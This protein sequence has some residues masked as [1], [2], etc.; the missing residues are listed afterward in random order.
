MANSRSKNAVLNISVGFGTQILILLLSFIGRKIFVHFLELDYLGINGLYSNIL[1][2]LA[3]AELGLGNV[4]QFFLYKPV[5]END[6]PLVRYLVKYFGKMYW[7]IAG[8]VFLLGVLLMP[9]LKYF[10]NSDLPQN[11]LLIYY[12]L[13]LLNSVVSYFAADKIALLAA[14]QDNRLQ[15]YILLLTNTLAQV[16][17]IIVLVVWHNY[18]FYVSVTLLMSILNV[19]LIN[20]ICR[21]KYSFL[22][23][24]SKE[25]P[26]GFDKHCIIDN[27]KSTFMY[28]IGATIVNN[29]DNI[30]ISAMI[31]TAAVGL[32]SNYQMVV[33]AIQGF[34]AIVSTSLISGIGNLSATGNKKR[35]NSVFNVILLLYHLIAAYG[36]IAF[37]F[38]FQDLIDRKSVV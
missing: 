5:V 7:C 32:Y 27:V 22:Y 1:S 9:F 19:A 37:Y 26:E 14:Y 34:I 36:A 33:L 16:G 8:T 10:I 23:E 38:L 18:F 20:L 13:F 2:V 6:K 12:V 4:T 28:K 21:K 15:K 25:K 3:L 29:T 11:E 24:K 35:M 17:Y 31:S 30:L